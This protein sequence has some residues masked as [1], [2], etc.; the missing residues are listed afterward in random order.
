MTKAIEIARFTV[1][2]ERERAFVDDTRRMVQL[3]AEHFEGMEDFTRGKLEDGTY[4]DV[5]TWSSLAHAQRAAK[6]IFEVP[7]LVA[8]F[9]GIDRVVEMRHGEMV[10]LVR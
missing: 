7:E 4:V 1:H 5:V 2:P 3:V 9:E 8:M 6:G 10:Y